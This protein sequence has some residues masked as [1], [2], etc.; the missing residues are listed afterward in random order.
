MA[1]KEVVG[2]SGMMLVATFFVLFGVNAVVLFLANMVFPT[3][4][5]LGT[6]ALSPLWAI[7][8]SMGALALLNTF[9][10]PFV[11]VYENKRGKMFS[12][13]EWMLAYFVI[14]LAGIWVIAR[15]PD[16]FGFGV[17][18]W[19]VV[20]VLAVALDFL[21]GLAMMQLAKVKLS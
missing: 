11:H 10:I 12:P 5:V 3:Q 15:F 13:M 1:K 9:S 19:M 2:N 7:V 20:G 16:Q 21:Q 6:L 8:H 18:S 17:T 4:V 14:N